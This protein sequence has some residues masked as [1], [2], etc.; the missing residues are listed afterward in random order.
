MADNMMRVAGRGDDGTAKPIKTNDQ[1]TIETSVT[2]SKI[3]IPVDIQNHILSD[4]IPVALSKT[5]RSQ[6]LVTNVVVPAGTRWESGFISPIGNSIDVGVRLVGT[7]GDVKI[8]AAPFPNEYNW[9][10]GSETVIAEAT[11]SSF[12]TMTP[13]RVTAP[14]MRV[15]VENK[16]TTDF[17]IQVCAI[18]EHLGAF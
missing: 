10:L 17:T 1:G 18:V 7:G 8:M 2:D 6:T 4:P 5:N 12:R 16:G 14:R 9:Q 3:A 15:Y 11:G 13:V